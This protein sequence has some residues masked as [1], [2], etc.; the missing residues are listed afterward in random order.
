MPTTYQIVVQFPDEA[1][2]IW[3]R[4]SEFARLW[5]LLETALASDSARADVLPPFPPKA[6]SSMLWSGF[7]DERREGLER[8]LAAAVE[9][10]PQLENDALAEFLEAESADRD[11]IRVVGL[12]E[13]SLPSPEVSACVDEEEEEEGCREVP[14]C[15][16][17]FCELDAE[18]VGPSMP[19]VGVEGLSRQ[20]LEASP[21]SSRAAEA[22]VPPEGEEAVVA[23]GGALAPRTA[24]SSDLD[25][26]REMRHRQWLQQAQPSAPLSV[27]ASTAVPTALP[28]TVTACAATVLAAVP[29]STPLTA[30]CD[31]LVRLQLLP[32]QPLPAERD[33]IEERLAFVQEGLVRLRSAGITVEPGRI[34]DGEEGFRFVVVNC[35]PSRGVLGPDAIISVDGPPI[36][37]LKRVQLI[38]L[39]TECDPR[40]SETSLLEEFVKP[41]FASLCLLGPDLSC[42]VVA[43]GDMLDI[44][45]VAFY[46]LAV[47]P[48][49]CGIVDGD[50]V[51][52]AAADDASEFRRI[53][54]VPFSD[55]LPTAYDFNVFQDY[56]KPYFLSHVLDRY[57]LGQSF[58][59]SSVQ[60]NVVA[61]EPEGGCCRVGRSTQVFSEGVLYPT[62]ANLLNPQEMRLLS[63]FPP[64]V[65]RMLLQTDM[66]GDGEVADRIIQ[67]QERHEQTGAT[68]SFLRSATNEHI[69]SEE[70]HAQ[71]QTEQTE[72]V[73]CLC[74]FRDGDTVRCLPCQHVFHS[75]CVDEWLGR[76]SHC[77]LCRCSF[78]PC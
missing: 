35:T 27:P 73:V 64:G 6:V 1:K 25:A 26:I 41:Y 56:V 13:G 57:E 61:V 69:W 2:T 4:Y 31:A 49:G 17:P 15:G 3:R 68:A 70:V 34:I 75:D 44:F 21:G 37:K 9:L 5:E 47:D 24:A 43:A 46:A 67:A 20:E 12:C 36:P 58:H 29:I 76:D 10:F 51:L 63:R 40:D 7:R 78:T 65:Q 22:A 32:M 66:F 54:V 16:R 62:A 33:S 53:H 48:A 23:D 60:F 71:L 45:D 74:K 59:C 11:A 55:T 14:E 19:V 28:T 18:A 50:T 72:C 8:F 38:C 77:P 52:Y 42:T 39:R 30:S